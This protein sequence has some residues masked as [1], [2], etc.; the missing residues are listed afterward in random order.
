MITMSLMILTNWSQII[1]QVPVIY[2][3]SLAEDL[4]TALT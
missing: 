4:Q 2:Q 3:K 1:W